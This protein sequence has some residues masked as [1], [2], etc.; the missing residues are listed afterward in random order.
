MIHQFGQFEFDDRTLLLTKAGRVIR[1]EPQPAK[2]LAL[3][4]ARAGEVITREDLREAIWPAGTH[5][6]FDRGLA[7]CLNALRGALGDQASNPRFVE[8][9]PRRGV[10]FIAPV[11]TIEDVTVDAPRAAVMTR[12][13]GN[14]H[15]RVLVA[16]VAI[17]LAAIVAA[18]VWLAAGRREITVAVSI[19]DNETGD[20]RYDT[21]LSL[22]ADRVVEALVRDDGGLSVIGNMP[23]VR[24]PRDERDLHR[25]AEETRARFVVLGQLQQRGERVS[26]FLQLIR[27]ADGAHVWVDRIERPQNDA[28]TGVDDDA[29]ARVTRAIASALSRGEP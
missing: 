26:L 29:A 20:P 11:T 22:V 12:P 10:R 1:I 13:A 24:V 15:A 21:T 19:F 14:V 18:G 6:D 17:A 16:A 7:Y 9:L 23:S 27:L 5:V 4:L 25:I 8:T 2:A 28:L 3:L